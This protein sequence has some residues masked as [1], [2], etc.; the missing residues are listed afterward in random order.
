M[1]E[2][3]L[4][5]WLKLDDIHEMLSF[6]F[7]L[8]TLFFICCGF[9]L[10]LTRDEDSEKTSNRLRLCTICGFI[11]MIVFGF[12][13]TFLPTTKQY[14]VI[15]IVPMIYNSKTV[16][17]DLPELYNIAVDEMKTKLKEVNPNEVTKEAVKNIV[18]TQVKK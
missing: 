7:V 1:S 11:F 12:I 4:Y 16:Q 18:N 2:F 9:F 13:E 6:I 17:K 8:S 14:A 5:M 10:F 3:D 15:K